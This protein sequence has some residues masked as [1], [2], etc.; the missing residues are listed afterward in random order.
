MTSLD[1][2]IAIL[3]SDCQKSRKPRANLGFLSMGINLAE[4]SA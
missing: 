1:F 3:Q 2:F 4:R